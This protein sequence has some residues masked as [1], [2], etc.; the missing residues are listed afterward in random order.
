MTESNAGG[1][2]TLIIFGASGDLTRRKLLPALLGLKKGGY[3]PEPFVILGYGRTTYSDEEFREELQQ[4]LAELDSPELAD[5][6][7]AMKGAV[8]YVSGQY[9]SPEGLRALRKR[10]AELGACGADAG[11]LYYVALP[12]R[13]AEDVLRTMASLQDGEGPDAR[14]LLEKPF[15][16]D[17]ES[18]R[19]FND[20]VRQS[21]DEQRIHRIDHYLAKETVRN[22]L[23]FRFTN[24]IFEPIW[25]RNAIDNVQIT[26][27]EDL[28]VG[29]RAGYYEQAGVVR[30]MLQNH[31]LQVL[32]L[33]A[34][35]P[36]LAGDAESIRD[37]KVEIFRAL[38]PIRAEDVVLGQYAGYR[39]EEGVDAASSTPTFV[40]AR[41]EVN[42]W[43]WKGVPFYVRSGKALAR[44]VT[45]VVIEFKGVPLC[46]L[47]DADACRRL[48]SNRLILRVQPEEGISL[49]FNLQRPGHEDAVD[50]AKLDFRYDSL[51]DRP[52]EAYERVI[53]DALRGR[54]T[55]FWR[56]D[57]VE[58]AW[59]VVE[60]VLKME[61]APAVDYPNYEVGTWGPEAADALLRRDHRTWAE[62]Y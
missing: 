61:P 50:P 19:T 48:Q 47:D 21:F 43:R 54:P 9:D 58:A 59:G 11:P 15:G 4:A 27:A 14:I 10:A 6:W 37:K 2:C 44:K 31:V 35:E 42:N 7:D 56:G 55:L 13:A 40:A 38:T 12:P 45:E 62:S 24:S 52:A 39:D 30:D 26:A 5:A 46:L 36:P 34:M 41:M 1:P 51:P 60:P 49:R 25:N 53:L 22:L 18:A 17:R 32:A 3:L 33:V 57:G 28:G 29:R 23:V 8:H 20:L 16:L